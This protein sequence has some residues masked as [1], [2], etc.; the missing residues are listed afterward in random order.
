M[1]YIVFAFTLLAYSH[2]SVAATIA[3]QQNDFELHTTGLGQGHASVAMINNGT[4][5]M[6]WQEQG[7]QGLMID[8]LGNTLARL[9]ISNPTGSASHPIVTAGSN[10]FVVT[11]QERTTLGLEVFVAVLDNQGNTLVPKQ[12]VTLGNPLWTSSTV[13]HPDIAMNNKGEFIIVW[14]VIQAGKRVVYGQSYNRIAQATSAVTMLSTRP[15]LVSDPTSKIE[16][17]LPDVSINT[18][19]DVAVVWA[20]YDV[21]TAVYPIAFRQFNI[22]DL[23]WVL[24]DEQL[25]D[26]VPSSIQVR[27]KVSLNN[28]GDIATSWMDM[29]A[30]TMNTSKV[31]Y[32]KYNSTLNTWEAVIRLAGEL[33]TGTNRITSEIF[34]GGASMIAFSGKG[35]NSSLDIYINFYSRNNTLIKKMKINDTS[36]SLLS[37]EQRRP[38]IAFS[39]TTSGIDLIVTWEL[40]VIGG[41]DIVYGKRFKIAR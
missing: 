11:W 19:G 29:T 32:K 35:L 18:T 36:S 15:S 27:P 28:R 38:A 40:A 13:I 7:T 1:K 22:H 9:N 14:D 33:D 17:G 41:S 3:V 34:E 20:G 8:K 26:Y 21:T 12:S 30:A 5:L 37:F 25:L 23:Q 16:L 24:G 4:S 2:I 10:R 31:F 39:S 6:V